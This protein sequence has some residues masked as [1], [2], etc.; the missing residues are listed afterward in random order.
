VALSKSLRPKNI[1]NIRKILENR[2]FGVV[3][4][5]PFDFPSIERYFGD[6]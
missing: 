3:G 2:K 5:K 6:V 1:E 4:K